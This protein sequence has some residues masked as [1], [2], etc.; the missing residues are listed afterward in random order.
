MGNTSTQSS[1]I[2]NEIDDYS[3]ELTTTTTFVTKTHLMI[4]RSQMSFLRPKIFVAVTNKESVS[5]CF[6]EANKAPH[7][8]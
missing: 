8:R 4:I 5:I 7:W 1:F 3:L 6:V 2:K